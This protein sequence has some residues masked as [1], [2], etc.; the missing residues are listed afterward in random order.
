MSVLLVVPY[1]ELSIVLEAD[2]MHSSGGGT[3]PGSRSDGLS[4]ALVAL[5]CA[6][7]I[8][9][10]GSSAKSSSSTAGSSQHSQGVR[11]ADCMRFHGV[12]N[13]PDPSVGG[14]FPLRTSGINQQSP[15]FLSAQ[16][17]CA[18]LQPGGNSQ[19]SPISA[20]QQ[21][22]MVANARCIRKHGVPNFPDP[23][24]GPGGEGAGVAYVGNASAPA[25]QRAVKTCAHV[26]TP[27][28][29]V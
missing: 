13:F 1:A 23:T 4:I 27:I 14:G 3:P 18:N 12:P 16:R 21:A 25:F 26:G 22:G 7:A 6:L 24:F 2:E 8:A 20:A 15:A 17:G 9:A 5:S 19:P 28:P 29:G 10:C 11:Y